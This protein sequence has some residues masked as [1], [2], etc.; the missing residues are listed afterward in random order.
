M[1][2]S[3]PRWTCSPLVKLPAEPDEAGGPPPTKF[4][5]LRDNLTASGFRRER[6]PRCCRWLPSGS[7]S[8]TRWDGRWV[9]RAS[10][11]R[12]MIRAS[13]NSPTW[14]A[15]RSPLVRNR[16]HVHPRYAAPRQL[17]LPRDLFMPGRHAT[18]VARTQ[19]LRH[20]LISPGPRDG[21]SRASPPGLGAAGPRAGIPPARRSPPPADDEPART[22]PLSRAYDRHRAG[23]DVVP[24]QRGG[25]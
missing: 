17:T 3:C 16:G 20:L 7:G 14:R 11:V 21:E 8:V 18:A 4:Y 12:R 25:H 9:R 15:R 2:S 23:G 6:A 24:G 13:A 22:I 1:R 10:V 19:R 5:E